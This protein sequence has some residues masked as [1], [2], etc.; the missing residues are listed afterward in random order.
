[1]AQR[2]GTSNGSKKPSKAEQTKKEN[3]IILL[4]AAVLAGILLVW[5][6]VIGFGRFSRGALFARNAKA[7]TV[8]GE[9]L[10]VADYNFYFY[11]SYYEFLNKVGSD[12]SGLY[13]SPKEGIP[14]NKQYMDEEQSTTWQEYFDSRA[15]TLLKE[16]YIY[17]HMAQKAGFELTDDMLY[18]INYDYDEK[19]WFEAV[20]LSNIGEA[21]YLEQNYGTGMTKD[22]YLRNLT[23][24]Y[25]AKF[26]KEYYKENLTFDA[27]ALADY[28]ETK[29]ADYR[30]VFYQMFYLAGNSNINDAITMDTA[31]ARAEE[32][33]GCK[34][35]DEFIT[36]CKDYTVFNAGSTY[37]TGESVLRR[38]AQW[39]AISYLRDWLSGTRSYGDTMVAEATN[40]Y[41][42]AFFISANDNKYN[43]VNL[44][45][46]T[47]TGRNAESK[48]T[49]FMDDFSE[50]EATVARFFELSDSIRKKNYNTT[51]YYKLS[52]ITYDNTTITSVPEIARDWAFDSGRKVG[53]VTSV[54]DEDG[55]WY[56]LYYH[57]V[58]LTAQE[59]MA[60]KDLR[61]ATYKE[62]TEQTEREV[63]YKEKLFF[64]KTAGR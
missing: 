44:K 26:Y 57:G 50:G 63:A 40:G 3:R 24:L 5:L 22:I 4:T 58:G 53:E 51:D 14:L 43:T 45:Y 6:F 19:I 29:A 59:V 37:W 54:C 13:S 38:E 34:E 10:T 35:L 36:M 23:V 32:L 33:S 16:T 62:W 9:T 47:V 61:N 2:Y 18:D 42:V 56:V 12:S 52:S 30:T 1:M 55:N 25:T 41:Y 28:Y 39:T 31:R 15:E 46:F 64:G 21:A 48:V 27:A 7:V 60:D 20:S 11:R 49:Q 8:D 17:Y